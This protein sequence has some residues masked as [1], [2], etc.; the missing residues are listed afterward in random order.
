MGEGLTIKELKEII[1]DVPDDFICTLGCEDMNI[2]SV[3][4]KEEYKEVDF[5]Y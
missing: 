3:E 1:K 5:S 4:V 2:V